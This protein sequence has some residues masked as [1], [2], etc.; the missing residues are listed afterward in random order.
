[1]I[2]EKE[3]L[4]E[5][6]ACLTATQMYYEGVPDSRY[7]LRVRGKRREALCRA[8]DVARSVDQLD[9]LSGEFG[10]IHHYLSFALSFGPVW[11]VSN[12]SFVLCFHACAHGRSPTVSTLNMATGEVTIKPR[13]RLASVH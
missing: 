2:T 4:A 12:S 1:M 6:V 7:L 13:A 10:K 8:L 5:V 11:P 9:F 3:K